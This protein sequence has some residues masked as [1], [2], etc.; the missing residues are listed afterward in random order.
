MKKILFF[1]MLIA[2]ATPFVKSHHAL[3]MG[4]LLGLIFQNP[5]PKESAKASKQ[6]LKLAVVGLGFGVPL[7]KVIE[8]GKNSILFTFVGIIFVI[9]VGFIIGKYMKIEPNSN[10]LISFGTAI[11]GGSAIA[12]LSPVID[13]N[14]KE[15]AISLGVV[16]SLNA[17]GLILFPPIGHILGM[18]QHAFGAWAALAIH[19]TSSVV[20][21]T[22]V[23]GNEALMVG[24][25]VKLSRALWIAPFVIFFSLKNRKGGKVN[26]P[27]FILFF[28][29]AAFVNSY[30][31]SLKTFWDLLYI[32]SKQLLVITLFLIGTGITKD[33]LK[34]VGLK[35]ILFGIVLWIIVG[36]SS[37]FAVISFNLI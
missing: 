11:C 32:S 9:S 21:A 7:Y 25:T 6:L 27:Y 26:L 5:Y 22:S 16:F 31:H 13:A 37:Y 30:F 24:T 18:S 8:V 33:T 12:A 3:L 19:D 2:S 17:L 35:P 15:I 20:G 23:Y 34:K 29:L 28:I 4:I 1:V 36:I 14:E 10:K